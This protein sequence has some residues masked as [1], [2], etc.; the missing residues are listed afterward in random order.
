[1]TALWQCDVCLHKPKTTANR[2]HHLFAWFRFGWHTKSGDTAM[3]QACAKVRALW[4]EVQSTML[5]KPNFIRWSAIA[6]VALYAVLEC[7]R[8]QRAHLLRRR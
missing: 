8:L 5:L 7:V 6:P 2:L 3:S 1:M 4:P